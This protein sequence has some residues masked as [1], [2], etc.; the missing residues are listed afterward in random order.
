MY[1]TNDLMSR[2]FSEA[3]TILAARLFQNILD[4]DKAD[5]GCAWKPPGHLPM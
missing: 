4:R 1:Q 5:A 3:Y 2:V